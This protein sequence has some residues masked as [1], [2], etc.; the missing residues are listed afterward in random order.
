MHAVKVVIGRSA[1]AFKPEIIEGY[2]I[3]VAI[4]GFR[5]ATGVHP[6]MRWHVNH[7]TGSGNQIQ[8]AIRRLLRHSRVLRGFHDVDVEVAGS[9]MVG[10]PLEH[11]L[12]DSLKLQRSLLRLSLEVPVFP[13]LH[14]H[15]RFRCEHRDIRIHR[16]LFVDCQDGI[17][18]SGIHL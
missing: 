11:I 2:R 6:D 14:Q 17:A 13:R 8:K 7:V 9:R 18:I 1:I 10:I 5:I 3:P 15:H 12:D 4:R 16:I